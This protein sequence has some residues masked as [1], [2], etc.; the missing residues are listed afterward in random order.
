[1]NIYDQKSN[2]FKSYVASPDRRLREFPGGTSCPSLPAFTFASERPPGSVVNPFLVVL[3]AEIKFRRYRRQTQLQPPSVPLP[4]DV[5]QLV[6]LT[7]ELVQLLYWRPVRAGK[8]G[9]DPEVV[10]RRP[11]LHRT[12]VPWPEDADLETRMTIGQ[13][14]L[15]AGRGEYPTH[16]LHK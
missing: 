4:D 14:M 15:A 9:K 2:M 7:I 5:Q 3:N 16:D 10:R 12:R 13:D 1:M 8:D 11:R 6:D